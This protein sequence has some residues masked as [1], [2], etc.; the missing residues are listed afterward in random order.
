MNN[1]II[2]KKQILEEIKKDLQEAVELVKISRD[3]F[4]KKLSVIKTEIISEKSKEKK[5]ELLLK[6]EDLYRDYKDSLQIIEKY[7]DMR[8]QQI[9]S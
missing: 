7:M 1:S 2:S 4:Q 8:Y 3:L 6:A 5:K 9:K